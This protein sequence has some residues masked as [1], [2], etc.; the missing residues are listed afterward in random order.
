MN[1]YAVGTAALLVVF[2]GVVVRLVVL[3]L[4]DR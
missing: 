1:L 3:I 4:L 2:L